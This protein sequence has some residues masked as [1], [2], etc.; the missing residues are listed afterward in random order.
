MH[1]TTQFSPNGHNH[2]PIQCQEMYGGAADRCN[3]RDMIFCRKRE[4][5]LPIVTAWMKQNGKSASFRILSFRSCTFSQ[6]TR[7]TCKGQVSWDR[8]PAVRQRPDMIHMKCCLLKLLRQPAVLAS[9]I[10]PL[11]DQAIQKLRHTSAHRP[12]TPFRRFNRSFSNVSISD[13]STSASASR[14]SIAD[15]RPPR[16]CWSR[17]V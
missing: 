15:N 10:G 2:R 14:R 4:M 6:R 12:R 7:Y 1:P 3:S 9:F 11:A 13:N 5:L 16:S 17:S 8:F